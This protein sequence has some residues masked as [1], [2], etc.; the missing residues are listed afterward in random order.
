MPFKPKP[1]V[2]VGKGDWSVEV[3]RPPKHF[4]HVTLT[5]DNEFKD[6]GKPKQS[7]QRIEDFGAFKGVSGT[8]SYLRMDKKG[9]VHESH[10]DSWYWDGR[11]VE[12]MEELKKEQ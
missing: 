12:G 7:T 3:P 2:T 5:M 4:T 9:K 11:E 8:F 1:V 10:K 6:N